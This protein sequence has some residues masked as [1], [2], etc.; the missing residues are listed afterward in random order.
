M[1]QHRALTATMALVLLLIVQTCSCP[2]LPDLAGDDQTNTPSPL[3]EA[4]ATPE[5]T[6]PPETPFPQPTE[7]PANEPIRVTGVITYTSPFFENML[8]NS[9]VLLENQAGFAQ[10]DLEFEFDLASQTLGSVEVVEEGRLTYDL[11]L[12]I[13]PQATM[14]DV[15]ND[16]EEDA[17]VQVFAVA[18]WSNTW[19]DPFLERRDGTGWSNAYAS[20]ITD[21]DRDYEISG[22]TLIVWAPDEQ[23]GFP[24]AFGDD[25]MLFTE[26]DPVGPIPAG[27]TVVDLD[28][29]PFEFYKEPQPE[30]A[31]YEGES[32]VTDYSDLGYEEAFDA[33]FERMRRD[34][35]FTDEKDVDW[36]ALY[37]EFAPR[38]ASAQGERDFYVAM[39]DFTW[40]IPDGHIGLGG[41]NPIQ[42]EVFF[43][44]NGGSFGLIL[45]EL[46]DGRVIVADVL[47][48]TPGEE[49]GIEVGAEILTWDGQP[50]GQAIDQVQPY[51]GPYST[52]HH[53][54]LE[55][56]VF[57]TR[58]PPFES[59]SLS[60]RNP[61]ASVRQITMASEIEYDSLFQALP[62][63]AEDEL[64]LP[65]EGEVL[66]ESGLGYISLSTF[67]DN[68]NLTADL[69]DHY[70]DAMIESDVPGLIIDLRLNTG[71]NSALALDFAGYFFEEEMVIAE[72]LTF[73]ELTE[74]FEPEG[75]PTRIM[76]GPK[77]YDG[78]V[79]L[80][81]GPYCI[82]ACEGFSYA[83]TRDGR[84]VVMGHYPTAGAYGGVGRGQVDLPADLALQFPTS[85]AETPAGELLI[86]GEG[87]VPAVIVPVTEESALGLEDPVL[88]AA[89]EAL[90]E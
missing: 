43:E 13:A 12:P 88:E 40:A 6:T 66:D 24:T 18:Y 71:G 21:P 79:A 60:F 68:Y 89:I 49:A 5:P 70:I 73:N 53:R 27:Y 23:Q 74:A 9:F 48:D 46:T 36:D 4:S 59:V 76:P 55:Q 11:L 17:G 57:L 19:G 39:R 58:V 50:V 37:S 33:L 22:G 51:F 64:I 61:G 54:R 2:V 25:E 65:V 67:S 87:I 77:L 85:R 52:A 16:G 31:L 7:L 86:E 45:T 82:S 80:L 83:M 44:E 42:S 30:I 69:W 35:P 8:R 47:P 1:T 32:A 14:M 20:T 62:Y 63:F 26:D 28:Q 81:V 34:Y 29:E 3:P 75:I 90:T 38:V 56:V 78:P 84:S 72:H 15:D 10:R 41:D